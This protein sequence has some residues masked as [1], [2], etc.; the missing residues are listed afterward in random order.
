MSSQPVI[1]TVHFSRILIEMGRYIQRINLNR[2]IDE[3]EAEKILYPPTAQ[4]LRAIDDEYE[5]SNIVIGVMQGRQEKDFKTFLKIIA[6]ENPDGK[7]HDA[8]K[9]F[10]SGF[11]MFSGYEQYATW[12]NGKSYNTYYKGHSMLLKYSN[13]AY[14]GSVVPRVVHSFT[15][16]MFSLRAHQSVLLYINICTINISHNIY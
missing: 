8:T 16:V 14:T 7:F 1:P 5:K 3:L 12:P 15:E 2:I 10:F 6:A 4:S 11:T 13:K 9:Q